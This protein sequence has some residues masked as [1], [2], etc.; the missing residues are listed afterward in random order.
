LTKTK[1]S[2][3]TYQIKVT[4]RD[5]RPPIWRR[6]QVRSDITLGTLHKIIQIIMG[7][8]DTHLH[9][10]T[11][12]ETY[13]GVPDPIA[14]Y[15]IKNEKNVKLSRIVS[16]E[17]TKFV[18]EYDFGDYWCH[19]ILIEKILPFDPV[20]KSPI[21]LRGKRATPPEDVGGAWGYKDFLEAI[22]DADHPEHEDML[23]WIGGAFDPEEF[24]LDKINQKL[25]NIESYRSVF[26][27]N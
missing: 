15:E 11:V 27:W 16:G 22:F 24:D 13:Y 1:R 8:T 18:Y 10:F 4:L 6:I 26:Y 5:I 20:K 23:D 2:S 14:T 25:E 7:W 19:E 3:A 9:Q 21:C 12:G 17:G